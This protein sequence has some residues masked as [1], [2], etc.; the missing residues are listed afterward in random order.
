MPRFDIYKSINDCA[1]YDYDKV[2]SFNTEEEAVSY[3]EERN[4]EMEYRIYYIH[5]PDVKIGDFGKWLL[6]Q[7]SDNRVFST[8]EIKK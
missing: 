7:N 5:T 8:E 4:W 6:T 1:V 2:A 3:C